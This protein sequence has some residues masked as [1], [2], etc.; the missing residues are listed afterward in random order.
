MT[1]P[2]PS[3]LSDAEWSRLQQYLPARSPRGRLRRHCLRSVFDALFYLLRTGCPWRYLPTTFP[4][5]Q[6]VYYHF[7][8]FCRTGLWACLYRALREAERRRVGRDPNPSAALMDAQS[9]KTVAESG[10][11]R[12]L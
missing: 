3:N 12:G 11:I 4:P 8:Q 10:C 9:V 2:Y 7:R 5:W 6:T 1:T